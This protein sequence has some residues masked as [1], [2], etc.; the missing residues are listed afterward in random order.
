MIEF[1]CVD[2][3]CVNDGFVTEWPEGTE[4]VFCV[5]GATLLPGTN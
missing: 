1:W 3:N 5:C 2:T 4:E